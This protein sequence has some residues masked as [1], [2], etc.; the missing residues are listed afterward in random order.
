MGKPLPQDVIDQNA[1]VDS[2]LD[3]LIDLPRSAYVTYLRS[4]A[5]KGI[6]TDLLIKDTVNKAWNYGLISEIEKMK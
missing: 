3:L 6:S 4:M 2:T 5:A 1:H